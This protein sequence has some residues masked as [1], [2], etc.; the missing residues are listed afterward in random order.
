MEVAVRRDLCAGICFYLDAPPLITYDTPRF[1]LVIHHLSYMAP[2]IPPR[3]LGRIPQHSPVAH[4]HLLHHPRTLQAPNLHTNTHPLIQP[5]RTNHQNIQ[6]ALGEETQRRT[7]LPAIQEHLQQ[8][9]INHHLQPPGPRIRI[10]GV[11]DTHLVREEGIIEPAQF[12][13]VEEEIVLIL[14]AQ[15]KPPAQRLARRRRQEREIR[16]PRHVGRRRDGRDVDGEI[17]RAAGDAGAIIEEQAAVAQTRVRGQ[18]LRRRIQAAEGVGQGNEIPTNPGDVRHHIHARQRHGGAEVLARA[19]RHDLRVLPVGGPGDGQGRLG[20]GRVGE[21][22]A[23]VVVFAEVGDAGGGVDGDE[24]RAVKGAGEV[25]RDGAA[26]RSAGVDGDEEDVH[27]LGAEVGGREGRRDGGVEESW[28]G[29]EVGTF[30]LETQEAGVRE[31]AGVRPGLQVGGGE[32]ADSEF[33]SVG[34]DH[35]PGRRGGVPEHLWIAEL[36]AVDGEDGI[37]GILDKGVAAVGGVG[38]LLGFFLGGVE[39]ID[40]HNAVGLVGEESR[41]V[42]HVYDCR[43]AKDAFAFGAGI[44]GNWLVG[45]VVQIS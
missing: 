18:R 2:D 19:R 35:D 44:N 21:E 23:G 26:E 28:H 1:C 43:A 27:A 6:F 41:G 14:A 29:Y 11:I 40:G 34:N 32:D 45:P 20:V 33:L 25:L 42:V 24:M 7:P 31:V 16:R 3:H 15:E 5:Q 8:A 22:L 36:G 37:A 38:N 10:H 17:Q 39:R 9:P 13:A 4:A 12:A 30:V